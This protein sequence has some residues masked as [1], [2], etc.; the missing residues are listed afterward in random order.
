[1][2]R[3]LQSMDVGTSFLL[4]I[5]KKHF[6]DDAKKKATHSC[7]KQ[8]VNICLKMFDNTKHYQTPNKALNNQIFEFAF[9]LKE[10]SDIVSYIS[11]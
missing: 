7:R 5:S 4:H 8:S 9:G 3:C 11:S 1:M 2:F 6:K 10:A